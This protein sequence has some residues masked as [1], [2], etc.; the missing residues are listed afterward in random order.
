MK[1]KVFQ[2]ITGL[3]IAIASVAAAILLRSLLDPI[4]DDKLA[5]I[6]LYGAVAITVWFAG[7]RYAVITTLAGYVLANDLFIQ[8]RGSF[9]IGDPASLVGFTL[10][11]VSCSLII[12]FGERANRAE[13]QRHDTDEQLQL[14]LGAGQIGTWD[15]DLRTGK[16]HASPEARRMLGTS[17]FGS[18]EEGLASVHPEDRPAIQAA[19]ERAIVNGKPFAAEARYTRPDGVVLRLS[20]HGVVRV[21]RQGRPIRIVAAT[22]DQTETWRA[23]ESLRHERELLRRII[24]TIPV[25]ITMFDPEATMLRLNPE[26]TRVVGWS[27]E[28]AKG[29]SLMEEIYPDPAY[30]R[31][32][33]DFM[34]SC[35]EGW[36]DVRMRTRDGRTIETSWANI[37]LSDDT[38]VGIGIDITERKRAEVALRTRNRRLR[39]LF[40]AAAVTLTSDDPDAMLHALFAKIRP[41][42]A[43]DGY[44]NYMLDE[45]GTT[46][47]L[48]SYEGA[49]PD[50]MREA[51]RVPL[52]QGV[53]GKVAVTRHP[54]VRTRV[55]ESSDGE[56]GVARALGLRALIC[57]PLAAGD[58]LIGTLTLA[59]R[60]RDTF[61]PDELEFAETICQH[62]TLAYE[63]IRHVRE[64][65]ESGR[66]KDEF[67]A[68]LAHELRNPLAPIRNAADIL[69]Q[70]GP[71]DPELV[72]ARQVIE[73]QA[74]HLSRLVDDL[75]DVSRIT[76][77]K[78]ELRRERIPVSVIV[79]SAVETARPLIE[80][81]QHALTVS[82]PGEPLYVNGDLT[83]IAQVVSNL[84]TNAAKYTPP[85]GRIEVGAERE[86]DQAVL[87]VK[88]N[89]VGIP[90]EM[91]G[92]I[93]EMFAQVDSS[94]ERT[95]GGL[96]IGLTLARTLVELHG[97]SIEARSDGA[98]RGSEFLVRLPLATTEPPPLPPPAATEGPGA[99]DARARILVVDDNVDAAD[100][101]GRLLALD[102]Y[103]VRI[104]NGGMEALREAE[105]FRPQVILLDIGLPMMN[106][107]DVARRLRKEPWGAE[108]RLVA[109][110]GWGQDEDRRR[111]KEAG[112]DEHVVKP[113]DPASL[114]VLLRRVRATRVGST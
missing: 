53:N 60:S 22:I 55:Q 37:R 11:L 34:E 48:A 20:G 49:P 23:A 4:L 93:F 19:L 107:Y 85:S 56:D 74:E 94:L 27:T 80:G 21:D 114:R 36:M 88:D 12:F 77:G 15:W 51:D 70:H 42:L 78:I 61:E 68:T 31:Q 39:L 13:R 32:V 14:A 50:V 33:L 103:D 2:E 104:A 29:V 87:R 99:R 38:R 91:L 100:S 86:G 64:L 97:G 16:I 10:Y 76:R 3:T 111:S 67:L 84:L 113:I 102:G 7:L 47:L 90:R 58:R 54:I 35:R 30:R 62:V 52:G 81:N 73:R 46:L 18:I 82:L 109:L 41:E 66:M 44:W 8:P 59:S 9:H 101:L 96:G 105:T 98:G 72:W 25:M 108:I 45:S 28:E 40:E 63:R 6:T 26:F 112:F 5:L 75:L 69:K 17:R 95:A 43:L 1:A 92:R 106:G 24:D 65:K 71:R 110:T 83:R 79:S 57:H 89:G